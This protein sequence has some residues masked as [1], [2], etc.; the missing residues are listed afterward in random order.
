MIQTRFD[1][2]RSRVYT[3]VS[4]TLTFDDLFAH[5]MEQ[6][7][8]RLYRFPELFDVTDARTELS[9]TDIQEIARIAEEL[10]PPD[11]P[12]PLAIV[13]S[14]PYVFGMAH[15]YQALCE[16]IRAVGVFRGMTAAAQ[17][18]SVQTSS[19]ASEPEAKQSE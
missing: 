3:R 6:I 12:A 10:E 17:W 7:R 15:M 8:T 1:S 13:A 4:G 11:R 16:G 9:A 2:K 14:D 19:I 5:I 18:L